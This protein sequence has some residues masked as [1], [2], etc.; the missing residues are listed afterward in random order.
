MKKLMKW[1]VFTLLFTFL[2]YVS[3]SVAAESLQ[4]LIDETSPNSTLYLKNKTYEGPVTITKPIT[5]IGDKETKIMSLS[6]GITIADTN[7]ITLQAIQFE[8]EQAPVL[9]EDSEE[10]EFKNLNLIIDENGMEFYRVKNVTL[11]DLKIEGR[12]EGHFSKKPNG[13]SLFEGEQITVKKLSVQNVQDGMYFEKTKN[14]DVQ[15]TIVEDGRYGLHFMYGTNIQL[16]HNTVKNNVSGMT[17]MVVENAYI[18]HN[19]IERQLQ[20]NSNGMYLYDIE[21]AQITNNIF[22]ENT[23]ATIWNQVKNTAFSKNMFQSN[24]TVIHSRRS[25]TV[26]VTENEFQGNI[27]TARSDEIGFVLNRNHY[28]DYNGYDF[29]AD[30]LGDTDYHSFT[31]FGQWMVRKPVYQYYV[32]SPSVTLLN[33][34][35]QQLSDTQNMVLVDKNPLMTTEKKEQSIQL[36]WLHLLGSTAS[37]FVLFSIWRKLR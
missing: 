32:E 20:L 14:V 24:G 7:N 35:D 16:Q 9:V 28:D 13:I 5:I 26:T 22:K 12:K 2:P 10:I 29:N 11:S 18:A 25:P 15:H 6:T 31:S 4:Q 37:L 30:G 3:H 17:I 23:T 27:L 8:T 34:L 33:K 36:N 21:E 1:A 19:Q